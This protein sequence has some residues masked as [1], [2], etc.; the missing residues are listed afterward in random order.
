MYKSIFFKQNASFPISC[1]FAAP[2]LEIQY[3]CHS[4]CCCFI[5]VTVIDYQKP[6]REHAFLSPFPH[7]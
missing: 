5:G 1:I 7:R 2:I 4:F 3:F 6:K